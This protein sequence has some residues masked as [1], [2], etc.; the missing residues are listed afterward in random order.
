MFWKTLA[1]YTLHYFN[2]FSVFVQLQI[3]SN[4][5]YNLA[6]NMQRLKMQDFV[7]DLK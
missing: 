6:I 5:T 7:K 3:P 1:T 2:V 4:A